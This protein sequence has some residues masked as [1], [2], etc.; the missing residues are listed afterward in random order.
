MKDIHCQAEMKNG[1][2][3]FHLGR[4]GYHLVLDG[5]AA[6][7]CSQCGEVYFGETEGYSIQ[8]SEPTVD[9]EVARLAA[10]A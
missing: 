10:A 6:W 7:I 3:P 1:V 9:A 2:A 4:N 5:I 8:S